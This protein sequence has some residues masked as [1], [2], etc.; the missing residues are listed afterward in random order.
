[1]VNNIQT[2][3]LTLQVITL[4]WKIE[5]KNSDSVA[6]ATRA[7]DTVQVENLTNCDIFSKSCIFYL[8]Q[9]VVK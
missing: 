6:M 2:F 8:H 7:C 5:K 4:E 1:M 3:S 9:H